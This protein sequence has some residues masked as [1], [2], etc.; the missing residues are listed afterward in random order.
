MNSTVLARK[1][2]PHRLET[3]VGQSHVVQALT[4]ALNQH[5]LHHAYLFTGTRGVGKTTIARIISKCLNCEKGISA[6][7]CDQCDACLEIDSGRFFD[8][9]EIDA[10]SRT[11]VEDT[12]DLLDNVQYAPTKGRYKVYLIDEAHM[13]SGHSFNALLKTL[14]EPPEHVIFLLATTDPQKLPATVLSR[15]LQFHLKNLTIEQISQHMAYVLQQEKIPYE[16]AALTRLAQSASG[17]MRDGLSLLDQAIAYSNSSISLSAVSDMLGCID[18]SQLYPLI[19]ALVDKDP[20]A[21][22]SAIQTMDEH[23]ADY[24]SVLEEVISIL[25]QIALFQSVPQL[26]ITY[27]PHADY[28]K[29]ISTQLTAQEVQLYYQIGL[30][31]RRDFALAPTPRMGFEMVLL[32]M[33]AFTPASLASTATSAPPAQPNTAKPKQAPSQQWEDIVKALNLSG[34]AGAIV[35]HCA[36]LERKENQLTLELNAAHAPLLN[37]SHKQKIQDALSQYFNKAI[38]LSIKVGEKPTDSPAAKAQQ[39]QSA[40][41]AAALQRIEADPNV[42]AIIDTFN[43]KIIPDSVDVLDE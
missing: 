18:T 3:L 22:F 34:P 35:Q 24:N 20:S 14:E 21:L 8:L 38:Q 6:S 29:T 13:L 39:R 27:S 28:A 30:I 42:Q 5:R 7:P 10:A 4:N 37:E 1:W 33:L 32:R 16:E 40:K 23:G 11:K 26:K 17:S 2:R 9:I 43:A 25:H 41:K 19:K 31:G 36:M 12:R 15:C